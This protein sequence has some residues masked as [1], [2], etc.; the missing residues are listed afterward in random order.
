MMKYLSFFLIVL[1]MAAALA[2]QARA[3]EFGARFQNQ[4]PV[5]LEQD[6]SPEALQNI[7]PAAGGDDQP[8]NTPADAA[9][10]QDPQAQPPAAAPES[11]AKG[12]K[13]DAAPAKN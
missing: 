6:M 1:G 2:S 13:T 4:G 12:M 7:A 11:L 3:D 9:A 8:A 10:Q 5:A